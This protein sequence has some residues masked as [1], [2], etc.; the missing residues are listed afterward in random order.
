MQEATSSDSPAAS[1]QSPPHQGI[2]SQYSPQH[3]THCPEGPLSTAKAPENPIEQ[4]NCYLEACSRQRDR[5]ISSESQSSSVTASAPMLGDNSAACQNPFKFNHHQ[6]STCAP[7]VAGRA[8]PARVLSGSPPPPSLQHSPVSLEA[9]S[10]TDNLNNT[11]Q[12]LQP[13]LPNTPC[14]DGGHQQQTPQRPV[15]VA[16]PNSTP[17]GKKAE[18]SLQ[19]KLNF[20]PLQGLAG[21]SQHHSRSLLAQGDGR[22][23]DRHH[24]QLYGTRL[25]A[26]NGNSNLSVRQTNSTSQPSQPSRLPAPTPYKAVVVESKDN[27]ASS[28]SLGPD[29]NISSISEL[30]THVAR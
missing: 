25:N 2:Q 22:G 29:T 8:P 6:V 23:T 24:H 26:N 16:L 3:P 30:A 4:L 28:P 5:N 21:D 13:A 17:R 27:T 10:S 20:Q 19:H 7:P 15:P 11:F 1:H 9:N 14:I 18:P 12:V